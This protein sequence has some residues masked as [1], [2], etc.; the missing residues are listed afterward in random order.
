M[1]AA[2]SIVLGTDTYDPEAL[3][4]GLL[5]LVTA[6]SFDF[7]RM[8]STDGRADCIETV[9]QHGKILQ[10]DG[11]NGT[12]LVQTGIK[13]D[14]FQVSTMVD[15]AD[16]A[17]AVALKF[18]YKSVVNSELYSVVC[19]GVNYFSAYGH[20]YIIVDVRSQA[21]RVACSV[22]GLTNGGTGRV[23]AIWTM[24]PVYVGPAG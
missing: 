6:P 18:N 3:A 4:R 5:I 16:Y 21:S 9:Y 22:G 24:I 1:S 7:V 8:T 20:K 17:S 11:V 2:N 14:P 10:R 15:V 23:D 13:G 19:G 12:A